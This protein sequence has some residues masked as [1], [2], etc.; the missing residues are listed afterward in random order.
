VL[1]RSGKTYVAVERERAPLRLGGLYFLDHR[2]SGA[3]NDFQPGVDPRRLL[4]SAFIAGVD[5]RRRLVGLLDLCARLEA[6]V[7]IW[8]VGADY[9]QG[10]GPLADAIWEHASARVAEG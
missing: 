1:G 7:P 2:T 3:G 10:A 6:T 4:G 5:S 9:D 8:R